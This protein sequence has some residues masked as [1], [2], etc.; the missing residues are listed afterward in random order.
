MKQL[1]ATVL[2]LAA[3]IWIYMGTIGGPDGTGA[4]VREGGSKFNVSIKSIDP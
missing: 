4:H 1:L 3:A 2:L